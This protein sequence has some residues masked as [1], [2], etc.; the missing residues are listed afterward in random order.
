MKLRASGAD[1]GVRS[2]LKRLAPGAKS[3]HDVR[4]RVRGGD[5]ADT[6]KLR[7]PPHGV[8]AEAR[9][10]R[11]RVDAFGWRLVSAR[12]SCSPSALRSS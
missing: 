12:S 2:F 7:L 5:V 10:L 1:T 3:A 9:V 4:D 11:A 6:P 8:F